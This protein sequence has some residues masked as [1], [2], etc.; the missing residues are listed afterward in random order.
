MRAIFEQKMEPC[1][2]HKEGQQSTE[3]YLTE[4]ATNLS[5]CGPLFQF[6][7]MFDTLFF[8]SNSIHNTFQRKTLMHMVRYT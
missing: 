7:E 4:I 2:Q 8:L 6:L 5:S 3:K 1:V